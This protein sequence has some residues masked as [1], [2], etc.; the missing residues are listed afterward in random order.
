M[1]F[2]F[3]NFLCIGAQKSGTTWLYKN[4]GQHPEVWIPPTKEVHFFDVSLGNPSLMRAL[5]HH[6]VQRQLLRRIKSYRFPFKIHEMQWD[7]HYFFRRRTIEWYASIFEPG[8]NK[9]TGDITPGYSTLDLDKVT[10]VHKLMPHAKIIFFMR[11]PIDRMWSCVKMNIKSGMW[12]IRVD[13]EKKII[14]LINRQEWMRIRGN[15]LHT[16][17]HW[18]SV[19]PENQIFIGFFEEISECPEDLLLRLYKFLGICASREIIPGTSRDKI[20]VGAK[21]SIPAKVAVYLANLYHEDI[22]ELHKLFGGYVGR[23]LEHAEKL[24]DSQ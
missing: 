3:P 16:L 12:K 14:N 7:C 20:N 21:A 13:D 10:L 19:Y 17:R 5:R 23:W 6:A 4:L 1:L 24:K 9:V 22:K 15:Y 8:R 11:D 2:M 18:K